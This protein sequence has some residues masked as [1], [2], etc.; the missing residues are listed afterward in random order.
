MEEKIAVEKRLPGIS[1]EEPT[2][3][4]RK[5]NKPEEGSCEFGF[6]SDL[7]ECKAL[8]GHALPELAEV[9]PGVA[10]EG[11]AGWDRRF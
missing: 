6:P 4:N 7:C 2:L 5:L 10:E 11:V 3:N 9:I 1:I 8:P